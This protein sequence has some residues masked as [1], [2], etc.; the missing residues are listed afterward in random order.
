ML[1]LVQLVEELVDRGFLLKLCSF[2]MVAVN[3]FHVVASGTV[4]FLLYIYLKERRTDMPLFSPTFDTPDAS[5]SKKEANSASKAWISNQS[6][7]Q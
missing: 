2:I 7:F 1:V 3:A 5:N 6:R 4:D